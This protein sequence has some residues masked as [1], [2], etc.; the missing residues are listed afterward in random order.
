MTDLLRALGLQAA[1]AVMQTLLA[2]RPAVASLFVLLAANSVPLMALLSG[3]WGAGDVLIAYWLEN[4]AI[5]LWAAVRIATSSVDGSVSRTGTGRP[6]PGRL[7]GRP[8]GRS[9]P[10]ERPTSPEDDRPRRAP[11]LPHLLPDPLRGLHP[12]PRDLHVLVGP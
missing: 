10:V 6:A 8:H 9:P 4:V 7:V 2:A 12:R 1:Y 11:A 5:G 3:R